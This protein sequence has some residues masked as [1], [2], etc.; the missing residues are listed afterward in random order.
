[1]QSHDL[2][3]AYVT[4]SSFSTTKMMAIFQGQVKEFPSLW[5]LPEDVLRV[6]EWDKYK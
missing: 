3:S 5:Q 1:M 4:P 6:S 2:T